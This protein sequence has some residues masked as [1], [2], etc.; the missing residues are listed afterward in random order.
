MAAV[1][2]AV[3]NLGVRMMKLILCAVGLMLVCGCRPEQKLGTSNGL[4]R[5]FPPELARSS[6]DTRPDTNLIGTGSIKFTD[7]D[8]AQ[9]FALY[10]ELSGRPVIRSARIPQSIKLTFENTHAV[11]RAQALQLFD[12]ALAAQ[13]I[14]MIYQGTNSVKAVHPAEVSQETAP[15][16]EVPRE[17]LPDSSSV[18]T[19]HATV[20]YIEPSRAVAALQQFARLPNSIMAMRESRSLILRDYSTNVRRM[21]EVLERVDVP[22]EHTDTTASKRK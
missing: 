13:G 16:L 20:Q 3:G 6:F 21:L 12:T 10:Q 7:A 14:V 5:V 9:V 17:Q 19:Y 18:V 1:A 15:L 11:T 4:Q 22:G 2:S 8:V